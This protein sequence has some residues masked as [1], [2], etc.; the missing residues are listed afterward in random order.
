MLGGPVRV[1]GVNPFRYGSKLHE[2]FFHISD[3]N[4][5]TLKEITE[6]IHYLADSLDRR[7]TS[8]ALRTIRATPGFEVIYNEGAQAYRLY[9]A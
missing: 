6:G 5:Y 4:W 7:R 2:I 3:G 9:D 1:S 8:S